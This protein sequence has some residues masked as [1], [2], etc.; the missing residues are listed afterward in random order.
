MEHQQE[1]ELPA[2]SSMEGCVL[3]VHPGFVPNM[4]V[5]GRI[6]VSEELAQQLSDE[7]RFFK[8]SDSKYDKISMT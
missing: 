4:R 8:D 3:H 2:A 5:P 1:I 7:M 6:Y